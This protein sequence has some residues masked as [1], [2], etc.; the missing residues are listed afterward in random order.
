MSESVILLVEDNE[1][2][3]ILTLR[4]F[5]KAKLANRIVV[6]RDGVEALDFLHGDG[7][8][9]LGEALPHLVLLDL[10]L[11]RLDG[12]QVLRRIRETERTADLPVV[13]LTSSD[14][15]R[16]RAQGYRLKAN[17]YIRKPVDFEQFLEVVS[18]VGMYWLVLNQ[19]PPAPGGAWD[20]GG[21]G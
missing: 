16:D 20:S 14:E 8:P 5:Q 21:G 2:D 1:D 18:Q 9:E 4:A 11:P 17:S 10:Q 15:E 19:G 7:S 3:V 13:I 12:I 6:A